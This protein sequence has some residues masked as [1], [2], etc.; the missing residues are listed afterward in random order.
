M[1]RYFFKFFVLTLLC[2]SVLSIGACNTMHGVGKDVQ[3][4]GDKIEKEADEHKDH[5]SSL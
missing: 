5:D 4:A 1:N 2:A 3:K